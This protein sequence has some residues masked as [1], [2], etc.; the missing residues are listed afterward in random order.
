MFDNYVEKQERRRA[1]RF[2]DIEQALD[3]VQLFNNIRSYTIEADNANYGVTLT[4]T[5]NTNNGPEVIT[6][7]RGDFIVQPTDYD[8]ICMDKYDIV[9]AAEFM[10][11]FEPEPKPLEDK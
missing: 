11:Q 2:R 5:R 6:I 8:K 9:P 10:E 1:V 3:I 4:I 7:N